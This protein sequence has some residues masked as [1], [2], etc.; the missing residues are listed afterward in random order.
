MGDCGG[1]TFSGGRHSNNSHTPK[2]QQFKGK[3]SSPSSK[4]SYKPITGMPNFG[5]PRVTMSFG[6]GNKK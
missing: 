3:S 4:G 6:G 5:T 1:K 2:S